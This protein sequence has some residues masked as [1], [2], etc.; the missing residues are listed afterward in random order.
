MSDR[1]R[2]DIDED[3]EVINL[4]LLPDGAGQRYLIRREYRPI[5]S[6]GEPVETS[7]G[8]TQPPISDSKAGQ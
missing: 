6:Y 8:N 4:P 7:D 2:T 3:R 5:D 1:G